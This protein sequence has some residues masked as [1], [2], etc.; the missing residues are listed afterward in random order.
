M[1]EKEKDDDLVGWGQGANMTKQGKEGR[2][3]KDE[4]GGRTDQKRRQRKKEVK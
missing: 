1:E 3:R 4:Q 2:S